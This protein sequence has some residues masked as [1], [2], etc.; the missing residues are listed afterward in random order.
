[1]SL[2]FVTTIW[3]TL[4][5]TIITTNTLFKHQIA[6]IRPTIIEEHQDDV[7]RTQMA[8]QV[9]RKIP[10][11]S[12][13]CCQNCSGGFQKFGIQYLSQDLEHPYGENDE[14]MQLQT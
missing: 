8:S 9:V 5:N 4:T 6:P 3:L 10:N 1:M 7:V 11:A 12:C 2:L 13:T 14:R